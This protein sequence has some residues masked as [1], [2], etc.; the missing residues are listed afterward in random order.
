MMT[1]LEKDFRKRVCEYARLNG[2][3]VYYI[4]DS[5]AV[6]LNG[7][8]DLT[9]WRNCRLPRHNGKLLFAELKTDKGKL[10]PDQEIVIDELRHFADVY[11]WRPRD[12]DEIAKVL[13]PQT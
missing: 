6:T 1:E 13:G 3:K 4:P 7:Y 11:V 5:R 9:M 2:W 12:W 10:R 8:P